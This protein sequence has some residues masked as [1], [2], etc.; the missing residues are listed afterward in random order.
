M[1]ITQESDYAIKIV[2]Y[3]S[4]LDKGEIANAREISEAEKMSMKF[5]LKIL[6]RLCKVKLVE[7]FRGIKGGYKLK[8]SANDIS[9]RNV[10][11]VIQG[12]LFINTSL[13][14]V[15]SA[16]KVEADPVNSLLYSIQ[17]DVKK[18]LSDT[19][20]KDLKNAAAQ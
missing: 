11:E 12:D 14:N 15:S 17:E 20:F 10:I 7:S 2:L 13:K 19:S 1:K 3:L 9:L 16:K 5:A 4:K 8:K 18:K 6:R